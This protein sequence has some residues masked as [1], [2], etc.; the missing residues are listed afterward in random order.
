MVA[1]ITRILHY[2]DVLDVGRVKVFQDGVQA[3][4]RGL[5]DLTGF[6]A[7]LGT[8]LQVRASGDEGVAQ[9]VIVQHELDR[10]L[11][12]GP[13]QV[14]ELA[15]LNQTRLLL[16]GFT[17]PQDPVQQVLQWD[18]LGGHRQGRPCGWPQGPPDGEEGRQPVSEES[19]TGRF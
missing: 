9:P 12:I 18:A 1:A 15:R 19:P 4:Y 8:A 7:P 14:L 10:Q 16:R 11:H 6:D 3:L 5:S 17:D 13:L 2:L